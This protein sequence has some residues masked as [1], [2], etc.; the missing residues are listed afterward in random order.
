MQ[1]FDHLTVC[2]NDLIELLVINN[3]TWNNLTVC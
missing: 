3:N 1:L 2:K